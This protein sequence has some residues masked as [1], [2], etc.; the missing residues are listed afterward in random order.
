M[1]QHPRVTQEKNTKTWRIRSML[2]KELRLIEIDKFALLM[3]FA[4][5]GMIM[6]TLWVARLQANASTVGTDT[7][8]DSDAL[9]IGVVDLDPTDTYPGQDLSDNFTWYLEESPDFIVVRFATEQD[10][11]NALY[12]D[13]IKAYAVIPYG[14][15]GNI[16]GD[17]PAFVPIHISSTDFQ[18]QATVFGAFQ[19]AVADFRSDH[20]WVKGEINVDTIREFEPV[21]DYA[22]ASFGV[23]LIVF[24]SFIAVAATGAQAIVGDVPLNRM[25]LTPAT[26]ME[27]VIAKVLAYFIL[28]MI[29]AQFLLLLWMGLFGIVPNTDYLTLNGVLALMS[30]S[31]SALGVFISTMCRTRLQA[32]QSFL[33]I[34]FSSFIVGT[35][36]MDVGPVDDL[37]PLNLGRIM[38]IDTA[39]KGVSLATFSS[40][41]FR[42]LA[43]TLV[44]IVLAWGVLAKRAT[45]A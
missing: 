17:I 21:G 28:G 9:T 13:T 10:A 2:L 41:I 35:G 16:T 40:E 7:G 26:K 45:L 34:L 14:F 11:L 8:K 32:N 44:M 37:Y 25:L 23:F 27:A 5:P 38:I 3:V 18:S 39:F 30:I 15:E 43:F 29:Q 20:G 4:L 42:I 6:G 33:L 36:F 12:E 19:T 1:S 24:S 22:A 31:G